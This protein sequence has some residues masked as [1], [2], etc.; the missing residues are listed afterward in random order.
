[1]QDVKCVSILTIAH[2]GRASVTPLLADALLNPEY[3]EKVYAMWAILDAADERAIPSVLQYFA[4]NRSKLRA[5]KL[6]A[7]GDGLRYLA[8]FRDTVPAVRAFIDEVPGYWHRLPQGTRQEMKKHLPE[9][10]EEIAVRS[11]LN[12]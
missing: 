9:L 2:I 8:K 10:V 1:M 12:E 4:K 3:R 7:F 6:D 11:Q 5:G